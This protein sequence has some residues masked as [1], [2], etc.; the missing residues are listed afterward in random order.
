MSPTFLENA[1]VCSLKYPFQT[2]KVGDVVLVNHA[3]YGK[4]IKRIQAIQQ[5]SLWLVGDNPASISTE[6]MGAV[7]K[8]NVIGKVMWQ[9][10]PSV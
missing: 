9:V 2:L 7:H 10:S 6:K 3:D 8:K 1:F 4:M 5:N